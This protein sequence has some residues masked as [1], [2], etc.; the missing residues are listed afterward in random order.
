VT[1]TDILPSMRRVIA[2]PL[3]ADS[4]PERTRPT[5][6]DIVIGGV[7]L[8]RLASICETPCV[9]TGAA[10]IPRSGGRVSPVDDATA[11][12]VSVRTVSRHTSGAIVVQVDGRLGSAPVVIG[13]LRLIGRISTVHDTAVVV[14]LDDEG[15]SVA[16][17]D[18]PAD[19]R[20]GDLLAVPC[21]GDVTVGRL[22]RRR[23]GGWTRSW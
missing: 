18:L 19:L 4:W 13:E 14:G 11:I 7:S 21:P 3:T 9:H 17:V 1:L 16:V 2:D 23:S 8:V 5:V 10:L 20:V 12:V 15:P 22:R 6:D